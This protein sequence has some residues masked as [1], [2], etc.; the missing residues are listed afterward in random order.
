MSKTLPSIVRIARYTLADEL[1]QKS[2]LILFAVCALGVLLLRGCYHGDYRVNGQNLDAETVAR[3]LSNA[4]FH[5]IAAGVLVIAALLAMRVFRRDRNEGVQSCVMS[6][7]IARWQYV[8]GKI[9]GVWGVSFLFMFALHGMV[10]LIA[11]VSLQVFMPE[12]LAASLLC[13]LNLLFVVLAVLLLSLLMPDIVAF[14]CVLGIGVTGFAAEGIAAATHSRM[15]QLLSQPGSAHS[16]DL[17][18]WK[19]VYHL[20]PKLLGLQRSAISLFGSDPF[21]GFVTFYPFVNIILY[22]LIL[23]VLLFWRFQKEDLV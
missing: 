7:P 21:A 11:S 23:G 13:S 15:A 10:F 1:R 20:W 2:F 6:K 5:M 19:G 22:C 8:A 16:S 14:L 18:W 17:T 9:V 3:F 4:S 12:Y